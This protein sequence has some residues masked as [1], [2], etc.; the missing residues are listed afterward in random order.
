[1]LPAV[2]AHPKTG[3]SLWFNGVHT[4]HRSY[5]EE[6]DHVDTTD[7]SPMHTTFADGSEIP[8]ETIRAVRVAI[9]SNSVA[10]PLVTGEIVV[11]D[12]M[13]ASHGRMGWVPG[14]PRKVL[15]THFE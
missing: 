12:N 14:N 7:G 13:L 10:M 6:A 15:L 3:E 4:N 9:W 5:Y 8:D 11:V 2:F 1:M